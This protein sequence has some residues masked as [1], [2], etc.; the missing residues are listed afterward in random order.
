MSFC[1]TKLD[2]Y[3]VAVD[4]AGLLETLAE[5]RHHGRVPLRRRTVQE[6]DHGGGTPTAL[7]VVIGERPV[8]YG[9]ASIGAT[10]PVV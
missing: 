8:A 1:P 7:Q 3:I 10:R 6:S 4:I 2:R 5:R 9:P